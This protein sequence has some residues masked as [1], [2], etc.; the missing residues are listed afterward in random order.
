[1]FTLP[2]ALH[3]SQYVSLSVICPYCCPGCSCPLFWMCIFFLLDALWLL[4]LLSISRFH[5]FTHLC[6][7]S[8]S[9]TPLPSLLLCSSAAPLSCIAVQDTVFSSLL[10]ALPLL[11]L[12]SI[13]CAHFLPLSHAA[14]FDLL[15]SLLASSS[16]FSF[17]LIL[18]SFPLSH[19]FLFFS[20]FPTL[21]SYHAL[22]LCQLV[23]FSL[24][25]FM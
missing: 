16:P 9:C 17:F 13:S 11:L 24:V 18:V 25:C 8:F 4:L 15:L 7:S 10:L 21:F 6:V 12:L 3:L 5:A 23:V 14:P 2:L 20:I 22:S 19:A 1:M